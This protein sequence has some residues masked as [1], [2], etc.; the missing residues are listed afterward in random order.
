MIGYYTEAD[1]TYILLA[2][3]NQLFVINLTDTRIHPGH[4]RFYEFQS[5]EK[6]TLNKDKIHSLKLKKTNK[7]ICVHEIGPG[8]TAIVLENKQNRQ[9]RFLRV[10]FETY[11][12]GRARDL[13]GMTFEDY[14]KRTK[15]L[16]DNKKKNKNLHSKQN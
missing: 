11:S 3:S 1:K 9:I 14:F 15:P 5:F 8:Q 2:Y 13:K 4:P 12:N 7:I 10:K 16:I 6:I